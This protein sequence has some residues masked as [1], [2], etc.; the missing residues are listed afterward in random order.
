MFTNQGAISSTLKVKTFESIGW[1]DPNKNTSS[2]AM[3]WLNTLNFNKS[4]YEDEHLAVN[5]PPGCV[6]V[7]EKPLMEAMVEATMKFTWEGR[8]VLLSKFFDMELE[9]HAYMIDQ[10]SICVSG[11]DSDEESD[12]N[13]SQIDPDKHMSF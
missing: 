10:K 2:K 11:I 7:P 12:L 6:F 3:K 1:S 4:L 8:K 13:S 5:K 9:K